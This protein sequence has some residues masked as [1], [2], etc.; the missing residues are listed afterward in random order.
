MPVKYVLPI[1]QGWRGP[2]MRR[3]RCGF[4]DRFRICFRYKLKAASFGTGPG[5]RES[6]DGSRTRRDRR[7][8]RDRG[9]YW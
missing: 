2:T 6:K 5:Q 1:K 7:S 8:R 4:T 9:S 3:D